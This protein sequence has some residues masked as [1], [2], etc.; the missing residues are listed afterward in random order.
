AS[1]APAGAAAASAARP[2]AACDAGRPV[3]V[4]RAVAAAG[5]VGSFSLDPAAAVFAAGLAPV[6]CGPD[7]FSADPVAA[8][9]SAPDP[10]ACVAG[11]AAAF[12]RV[13]AASAADPAPA[14]CAPDLSFAD[15][16]IFLFLL[17]TLLVLLLLLLIL[18]LLLFLIFPLLI[19]QLLLIA[20]LLFLKLILI[21]LLLLLRL[22]LLLLVLPVVAL[23]PA[24]DFPLDRIIGRRETAAFQRRD[25]LRLNGPTS[26]TAAVFKIGLGLR[27]GA[28][29]HAP[30]RF[31]ILRAEIDDLARGERL[32]L[33][34]ADDLHLFVEARR[35]RQRRRPHDH[36]ARHDRRRR[37]LD[38]PP[39][40]D[41]ADRLALRHWEAPPRDAHRRRLADDC[42]VAHDARD[43]SAARDERALVDDDD[44][45]AIDE[46]HVFHDLA[47][48]AP[49]RY[50]PVAWREREPADVAAHGDDLDHGGRV[51]HDYG[52][53][54]HRDPV[55]A[56][57][58]E[59]PAAV[60]AR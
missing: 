1:A 25:R 57:A 16:A 51:A 45:R 8:D 47:A 41:D 55:P 29:L 17:F 58:V 28:D 5:A 19:L 56:R 43:H 11:P 48:P 52:A 36:R 6:V 40:G 35:R 34:L 23:L 53:A 26:L 15:P 38:L 14:V 2:V 50:E 33:A 54:A 22:L 7:L 44:A 27:H 32:S 60:V 4:N 42:G 30:I 46:C 21:A 59:R 3:P 13:P 39:F 20:L 12:D 10:A 31:E 24:R 49:P 9:F 18:A 37:P